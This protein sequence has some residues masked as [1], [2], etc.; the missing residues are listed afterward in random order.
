MAEAGRP[1]ESLTDILLTHQDIDHIG[2]LPALRDSLP[3]R[4]VTWASAIER[5]YVQGERLLLKITPAAVEAAVAALPP[6]MPDDKRAA[7]RHALLHPP[8]GPVDRLIG[9]GEANAPLE[10]VDVLDTPGHT[11]GHV[12]L[13][14]RPSR[15]LIAG[16]ALMLE[17]GRLRLPDAPLNIHHEQARRSLQQLA[18]LDIA[19]VVCYHGGYF[20]GDAQAQLRELLA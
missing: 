6:E 19:G 7:F 18:G 8:H 5:P 3:A 15:T 14:H 11:P 13:Y 1:L 4:P 17:D 16:D 12:S 10:D 9:Y 20:K 2:G